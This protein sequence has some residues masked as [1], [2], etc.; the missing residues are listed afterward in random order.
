MEIKPDKKLLTKNWYVLLTISAFLLLVA[1]ILQILIPRL[2]PALSR[3]DMAT[4]LWPIYAGVILLMWLIS[5]PIIKPWIKN[6]SYYIEE[7]R[8]T[9]HKG[10]F[11]KVQ[12]NIPYRA[13]TDFQ[14][15]RSIYDRFLGIGSIKIQTA[16]QSHSESGYE[17]QMSGLL[18]WDKLHQQLR[19]KLKTM[20]PESQA[21]TVDEPLSK[22]TS[23]TTNDNWSL[24]LEELRAIRKVLEDKK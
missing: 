20:H 3:G 5:V 14:L 12:Q 15:H 24:L 9:T 23:S 11:T 19:D 22:G 10:I 7:D 21:V 17:G 16:G 4:I 18:E 2:E 13:V 1:G 8:I 6:L